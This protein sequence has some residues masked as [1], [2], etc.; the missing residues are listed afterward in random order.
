MWVNPDIKP[1]DFPLEVV[2]ERI[3]HS[4]S[5]ESVRLKLLEA[6]TDT[7]L[8]EDGQILAK[9]QERGTHLRIG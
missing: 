2:T 8:S 6:G 7:L 9:L 3:T 4:V 1:Q 5:T